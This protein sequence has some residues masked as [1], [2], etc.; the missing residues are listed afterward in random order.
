M[1]HYRKSK[2]LQQLIDEEHQ[3]AEQ[4]KLKIRQFQ[5]IS[6]RK[7]TFGEKLRKQHKEELDK[8]RKQ[9]KEKEEKLKEMELRKLK[10]KSLSSIDIYK[11]GQRNMVKVHSTVTPDAI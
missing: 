6:E 7:T 11:I 10:A 1:T 4:Q 3:K 8:L 9:S 5:N 2:F